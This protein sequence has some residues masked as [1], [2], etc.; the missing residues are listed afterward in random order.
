MSVLIGCLIA[1]VVIVYF[2]LVWMI[3]DCVI[4]N[5]NADRAEAAELDAKY[6]PMRKMIN[7]AQACGCSL[8]ALKEARR[9]VEHAGLP[10]LQKLIDATE[11]RHARLW[12]AIHDDYEFKSDVKTKEGTAV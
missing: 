7:A 11:K 2:A 9:A 5:R 1:V 6:E 3:V 10:Q 8:N 4:A 12:D